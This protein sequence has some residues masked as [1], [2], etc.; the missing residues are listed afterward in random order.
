MLLSGSG[1]SI[2]HSDI[3]E[4]CGIVT[5]LVLNFVVAQLLYL[6]DA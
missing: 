6:P 5:A 2:V 3:Q 1:M 4:V